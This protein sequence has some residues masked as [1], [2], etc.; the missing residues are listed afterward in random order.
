[1]FLQEDAALCEQQ[2]KQLRMQDGIEFVEPSVF[3]ELAVSHRM[4]L[5]CDVGDAAVRG[6]HDPTT[7]QTYVAEEEKL[8]GFSLT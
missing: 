2:R 7:G 4:L 5:R 8:Y 3:C 1:M 6:L